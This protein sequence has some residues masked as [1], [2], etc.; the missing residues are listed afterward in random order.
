MSAELGL[1]ILGPVTAERDGSVISIGAAQRRA[2]LALLVLNRNRVVTT[3]EIVDALWEQNPPAGALGSIQVAVS[4]LRSALGDRG[5]PGRTVV[6]TEPA[7]YRL[8]IAPSAVDESRFQRQLNDAESAIASGELPAA[9]RSLRLALGEWT[10][11]ALQDLRGR[12]FADVAA[13]GLDEQRI[14]VLELRIDVDLRL[15]QHQ[16]VSA[17]LSELVRRH[18]LREGLWALHLLALYRCGRQADALTAY[19]LLRHHLDDELGIEPG[20]QL[21]ALHSSILNQDP[22]LLALGPAAGSAA[23]VQALPSTLVAALIDPSGAGHTLGV[24]TRLGRGP[25]N[26]IVIDD[27]QASRQHAVIAETAA[28]YAL[29]DLN[30]TNGTRVNGVLALTPTALDHDDVISIGAYDLVFRID[31]G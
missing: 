13:A 5:V 23:T 2:L 22:A 15:G 10:G 8:T 28:G 14:A 12:R 6:H 29:T 3:H 26:H 11:P 19:Q 21:R 1:R 20:S 24:L 4:G 17:E 25:A 31:A 18:P 16:R 27:P 9:A 30:S 7:G